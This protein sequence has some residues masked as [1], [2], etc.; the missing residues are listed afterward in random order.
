MNKKNTKIGMI[1]LLLAILAIPGIAYAFTPP[2]APVP[3]KS[4]VTDMAHK[5]T[6]NDLSKLNI[7]INQV[8]RSSSN[9]IAI[10][11]LPS[12]DG[13]SI[14]DVADLTFKSWKVG[15][16]GLDNGVLIVIAVKDRISRIETGKGVEGDLTDLQASDI[17]KTNLNPYLKKGD[18][19]GG[20]TE[21]VDVISK[22]IESRKGQKSKASIPISAPTNP[23]IQKNNPPINVE[24]YS[25]TNKSNDNGGL[26]MF[27]LLL[28]S[29]VIGYIFWRL[30]RKEDMPR[31]TGKRYTPYSAPPP[32]PAPPRYNPE[33]YPYTSPV[34][35]T[36]HRNGSIYSPP[37]V[38]S[39]VA[40]PLAPSAP[41]SYS[42]RDEDDYVAPVFAAAVI[43]PV[44]SSLFDDSPSEPAQ[45]KDY[46]EPSYRDS[47]PSYTSS[48]DNDSVSDGFSGGE[49]GGGGADSSWDD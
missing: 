14:K 27:S 49:S 29:A 22:T 47:E 19:Y 38:S 36:S 43:A 39:Y 28:V 45:S 4:Y 37:K 31:V 21:T 6:T 26:I 46:D 16:A 44:I 33:P 17:I 32:A 40:P 34:R 9:E 7:R 8:N 3:P 42:S 11:I 1:V 25:T 12:L 24:G 30:F 15:K 41:K 23:P 13:E 2:P 5:L 48:S 20:L 10:L 35:N 18:F